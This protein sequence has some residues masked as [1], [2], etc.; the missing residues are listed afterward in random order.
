M[1][2]VRPP[3]PFTAVS[4]VRGRPKE[5]A[6]LADELDADLRAAGWSPVEEQRSRPPLRLS[7]FA[8][9][10]QSLVVSVAPPSPDRLTRPSEYQ[11]CA[12]GLVRDHARLHELVAAVPFTPLELELYA[13]D[14]PLTASTP[15]RA[16]RWM[17]S[18]D[19]GER[20][21]AGH[22]AVFTIHHQ[23]DFVLLLEKA[24]ELGLD[25]SL[26][27][28]I[29]KQY[30]YRYSRRVDAH[31]RRRLG[32]PVYRYAEIERGLSDHIRRVEAARAATGSRGW[33][34][35]IVV[36]DG[37][38][39]L[40]R[41][42]TG[43]EPYLSFFKGVVE[44]T[45]SGIWA[46]RPFRDDV[47]VPIFSVA[48]SE[49]KATVEARGVAQAALTSLRRLM[50]HEKFE[51]RRAVVVGYGIV[52]Q[53]VSELLRRQNVDVHV[54]DT[55]TSM[56][57]TARER[58]YQ[59][60]DSLPELL[61]RVQPRYVF[62]CATPRAVDGESLERLRGDC[63]LISLT[64]RDAAFDKAALERIARR[65]P[66][67]TVGTAYVRDDPACTI[68]L[69][70]DGFPVNFHFA[71]SMPNQQSDLVM[72]SL[73]VGAMTL[74]RAAPEWPVGNDPARANAVLNAGELLNDFLH[75]QPGLAF[76]SGD[77]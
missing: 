77:P 68:L 4:T 54:S 44:Q 34:S 2:R 12:S 37:G 57:V 29:D 19:L 49:L 55:S 56:L 58:G 75:L 33:P 16:A 28:V 48:E 43:F 26:V 6:E 74:A 18:V 62:A 31:I 25:G 66:Y 5:V 1:T 42:L 60:G 15:R 10:E 73:L 70:A 30:R 9:D 41:L 13:H 27:T 14:M 7:R 50:P 35:T 8:A 39:V 64:S 46:L 52:G 20:P 3:L 51:G 69:V 47:K 36:D 21:L 53:A 71:E 11:L 23:T 67:G 59:I 65:R 76:E 72:A 63:A 24:L 17:P 38:Y 45:T 22:A 40:P 61:D 32:I